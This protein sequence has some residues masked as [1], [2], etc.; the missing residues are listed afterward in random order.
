MSLRAALARPFGAREARV[1]VVP[2]FLGLSA[3]VAFGFGAIAGRAH[4][5]FPLVVLAGLSMVVALVLLGFM[6]LRDPL[7]RRPPTSPP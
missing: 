2:V 6:M 3:L 4:D 1:V 5:F 7:A